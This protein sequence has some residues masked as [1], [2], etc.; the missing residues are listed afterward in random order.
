MELKSRRVWFTVNI[1]YLC[2]DI[3]HIFKNHLVFILQT[4]RSQSPGSDKK[5]RRKLP[6]VPQTDSKLSSSNSSSSVEVQQSKPNGNN[7]MNS[8][9]EYL[10]KRLQQKEAQRNKLKSMKNGE[11]NNGGGNNRRPQSAPPNER[12]N[13]NSNHVS[14]QPPKVA[15]KPKLPKVLASPA[16]QEVVSA[17]KKERPPVPPKPRS[18]TS[19]V[20]STTS[21]DDDSVETVSVYGI[22]VPLD[23]R[24]MKQ[25]IKEEIQIATATRRL[26]IDEME[27]VRIMERKLADREQQRRLRMEEEARKKAKMKEEDAKEKERLKK[28]ENEIMKQREIERQLDKERME[29]ES[30]ALAEKYAKAEKESKATV[31]ANL[32]KS[33]Y[34]SAPS[35]A[36][37]SLAKMSPQASPRR[38]KHRRQNSDPML[39][40]FSPIE[41]RDIE[42]D[43]SYRLGIEARKLSSNL[44]RFSPQ[45][46][47]RGIRSGSA[48]PPASYSD[49]S[50]AFLKGGGLVSSGRS[51]SSEVLTMI[52]KD[53]M[54]ASSHSETNIPL[55]M[56]QRSRTHH[57]TND[58]D[59][60]TKEEKRQQLQIEIEKRR[61]A[62][63]ENA[64]LRYEIQ[65][66]TE[67]ANISAYDF[68]DAKAKYKQHIVR[69]TS[70]YVPSG[71]IR[72]LHRDV[73]NEQQHTSD[74]SARD[75]TE[76]KELMQRTGN[77]T[78]SVG[79]TFPQPSYSST[80]YIAHQRSDRPMKP[81]AGVMSEMYYLQ[82]P[83]GECFGDIY[84]KTPLTNTSDLEMIEKLGY[85]HALGISSNHIQGFAGSRDSGMSSGSNLMDPFSTSSMAVVKPDMEVCGPTD[86]QSETSVT[87]TDTNPPS[88]KDATPA[89]PI[90]DDVTIRSRSKLR[91]IGS[92]PLSDDMGQY[93]DIAGSTNVF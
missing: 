7:S 18:R 79:K 51:K 43:M 77:S 63:E 59:K 44:S 11:S 38:M 19:S 48:T 80:E 35:S 54:L 87:T 91:Q 73:E 41:E 22:E 28:L 85:Q 46:G 4:L 86:T 24:S 1:T 16:K 31:L 45:L 42:N 78:S 68:E 47:R 15:P 2:T 84:Y 64:R 92:R 53:S 49:Y 5:S 69:T 52:D 39:A 6:S 83:P 72:P 32:A 17:V 8:D 9:K 27:E 21:Q 12:V 10:R 81:D 76:Y 90:L 82:A 75:Y 33:K 66:L 74:F 56:L 55:S 88:L 34:M 23:V 40:K 14:K 60:L 67:A 71:I 62:L 61:K 3:N 58:D 13:N 25:R 70:D 26:K 93:L 30:K 89:M 29:A 50:D 20:C 57:F 37:L 65:K 36:A